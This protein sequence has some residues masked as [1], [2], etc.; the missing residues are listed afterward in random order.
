MNAVN[1]GRFRPVDRSDVSSID[2]EN[3][4]MKRQHLSTKH[5]VGGLLHLMRVVRSI[6]YL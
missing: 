5:E 3:V 6:S 2:E 1:L 4:E